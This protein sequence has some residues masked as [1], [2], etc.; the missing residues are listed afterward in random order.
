VPYANNY[1]AK[2]HSRQRPPSPG[3]RSEKRLFRQASYIAACLDPIL[4]VTME[5]QVGPFDFF[6]LT[7]PNVVI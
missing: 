4:H 6:H 1:L 7:S 2:Q 3:T 5:S